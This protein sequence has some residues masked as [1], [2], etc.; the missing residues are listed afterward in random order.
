M[1]IPTSAVP[2]EL[3]LSANAYLVD[4]NSDIT[5]P[6]WWNSCSSQ[7]QRQKSSKISALVLTSN[8][9]KK[10]SVKYQLVSNP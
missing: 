10:V 5:S 7:I 9:S 8:V 6:D 4:Q 1:Y 3:A 2:L